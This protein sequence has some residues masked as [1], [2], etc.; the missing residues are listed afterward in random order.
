MYNVRHS[1]ARVERTEN[2]Y[3]IWKRRFPLIKHIRLHVK[4][5]V[6]VITATAILHNMAMTWNDSLPEFHMEIPQPM[7]VPAQVPPRIVVQPLAD[8]PDVRR[9]YVAH[10]D[11]YR[12]SS[13]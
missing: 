1:Q 10:R 13:P 4:D 8:H 5:A 6:R 2:I 12:T 11:Q 3:G 7:P 9:A